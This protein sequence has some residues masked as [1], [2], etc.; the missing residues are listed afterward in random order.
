MIPCL[1]ERELTSRICRFNQ[2]TRRREAQWDAHSWNGRANQPHTNG[3]GANLW[4]GGGRECCEGKVSKCVVCPQSKWNEPRRTMWNKRLNEA[5]SSSTRSARDWISVKLR[6]K[7]CARKEQ[8]HGKNQ[9]RLRVIPVG[10]N[11]AARQQD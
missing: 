3:G 7:T 4:S 5:E 9:G 11:E 2:E 8:K 6:S 10:R 1:V